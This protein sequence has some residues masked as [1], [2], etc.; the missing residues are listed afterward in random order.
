MTKKTEDKKNDLERLY[1][2]MLKKYDEDEPMMK[3][4]KRQI[5]VSKLPE[6]S[7]E[8]TYIT[9]KVKR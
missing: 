6:Q 9:G 4:L 5:R 7:L 1:E 3:S 8:S 2:R